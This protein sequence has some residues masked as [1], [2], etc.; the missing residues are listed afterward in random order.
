[1]GKEFNCKHAK[2]HE[3]QACAG[4]LAEAYELLER[5]ER[6]IREAF[7]ESALLVDL[8]TFLTPKR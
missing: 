4:C 2:R 1:M 3:G 8:H 5:S 7:P 6:M